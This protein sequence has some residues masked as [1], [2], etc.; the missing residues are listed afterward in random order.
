M[1]Q[2]FTANAVW[3]K[4]SAPQREWDPIRWGSLPHPSLRGLSSVLSPLMEQLVK[5]LAIPLSN[6]KT[7]AKW[8]VIAMRLGCPKTTA[9]SLVKSSVL[10]H[11]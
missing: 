1:N 6:Q 5:Q 9:K 4:R 10:C 11:G 3:S 8:L 7:V 2:I